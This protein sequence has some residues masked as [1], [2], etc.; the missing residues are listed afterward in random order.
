[1][2]LFWPE[3]PSKP[4]SSP[5]T[6]FQ[7]IFFPP[8]LPPGCPAREKTELSS[9]C[10]NILENRTRAAIQPLTDCINIWVEGRGKGSSGCFQ[11]SSFPRNCPIS[12]TT[13]PP[14]TSQG[15]DLLASPLYHILDNL[16]ERHFFRRRLLL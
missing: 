12:P 14:P 1:M 11:T 6:N 13:P 4:P 10:G 9:V 16:L 3:L 8:K 5:P 15:V 7:P 2:V